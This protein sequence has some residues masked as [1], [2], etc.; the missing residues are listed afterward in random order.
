M[1]L[2]SDALVGVCRDSLCQQLKMRVGLETFDAS[3]ALDPDIYDVRT[4]Y[5]CAATSSKHDTDAKLWF[6]S[7]KLDAC[8]RFVSISFRQLQRSCAR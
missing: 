8:L 4:R 3:L 6:W 1:E 5:L 7:D 2:E